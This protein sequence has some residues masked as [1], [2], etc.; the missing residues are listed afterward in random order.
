MDKPKR[1]HLSVLVLLCISMMCLSCK[2]VLVFPRHDNGR[3]IGHTKKI[4]KCPPPHAPAHGHRRKC[5]D[6]VEIIYNSD[7]GVYV[8]VGFTDH[9]FFNGHYY[10][11]YNNYW[12]VSLS[13][14]NAKWKPAKHEIIPPGLK[15]KH[16]I[17]LSNAKPA[18][19]WGKIKRK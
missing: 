11:F 1:I 10:R 17:K 14:N 7:Y 3:K 13:I 5:S 6:G 19:A 2:R 16:T 8:V 18:K 9:Y 15:A 12:Q 4:G